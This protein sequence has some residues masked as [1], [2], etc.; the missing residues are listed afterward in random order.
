LT[1]APFRSRKGLQVIRHMSV[2]ATTE[3]VEQQQAPAP[4]TTTT[5]M[6]PD[7]HAQ[8]FRTAGTG[9]LNGKLHRGA[10]GTIVAPT[11]KWPVRPSIPCRV[12][13]VLHRDRPSGEDRAFG[14][15]QY[16]FHDMARDGRSLATEYQARDS[17]LR[18][19]SNQLNVSKK[20]TAAFA[21]AKPA[22]FTADAPVR[23]DVRD[24]DVPAPAARLT[25]CA[26]AF[27]KP[28][29]GRAINAKFGSSQFEIP[30]P[31]SYHLPEPRVATSAMTAKAAQRMDV[32]NAGGPGPGESLPNSY[33]NMIAAKASATITS[34]R[35]ASATG[36]GSAA[37]A[38]DGGGS[39]F[40]K[41]GSVRFGALNGFGPTI[42]ALPTSLLASASSSSF[43][44]NSP[45]G[46]AAA[47]DPSTAAAVGNTASTLPAPLMRVREV[48]L[49]PH[50][51]RALAQSMT[52]PGAKSLR[53]APDLAAAGG[54]D[55]RDPLKKPS[56]VFRETN[57][58]RFGNPIVRY[59]MRADDSKVGPGSYLQ[60]RDPGKKRLIS[61][62]WALDTTKQHAVERDSIAPGPAFYSPQKAGRHSATSFHVR[63][64]LTKSDLT[65]AKFRGEATLQRHRPV[66]SQWI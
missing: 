60:L 64:N 1:S 58:D 16:R 51:A 46:G 25:T 48:D 35:A 37:A 12:E 26:F 44:K 18:S 53:A 54:A 10:V 8:S 2:E 34:R 28:V 31:G 33:V 5:A 42:G 52:A 36:A 62:S 7:L 17:S 43:A 39:F 9:L 29:G 23:R 21:S 41:S 59:A 40:N 19:H 27:S 45:R 47:A 55:G 50:V 65:A 11:N 22:G 6:L 30:G 15:S 3:A 4:R 61:S 66:K 56:A 14:S 20:G 24:Y 57:T 32:H 49:S 38:A 63:E 13:T